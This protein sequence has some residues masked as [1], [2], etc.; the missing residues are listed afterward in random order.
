M[1]GREGSGAEAVRYRVGRPGRE[2]ARVP[3]LCATSKSGLP[4]RTL[5]MAM[6]PRDLD[7][8]VSKRPAELVPKEVSPGSFPA[9]DETVTT[10][11]MPA[12]YRW[13]AGVSSVIAGAA[14]I[15]GVVG[16]VNG[17][18]LDNIGWIVG[19]LTFMILAVQIMR[20]GVAV[21]D[22]AVVVRNLIGTKR[23]ALTSVTGVEPAN[24]A[25]ATAQHGPKRRV[26]LVVGSRRVQV[27]AL[28]AP[29]ADLRV[30]NATRLW[31]L[32]YP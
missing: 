2:W 22:E 20:C 8:A 15:S 11:G 26:Y 19:G 23:I 27:D 30:A 1:V 10:L 28:Q 4:S 14:T 9:Q 32:L 29:E 18:G 7:R 21:E 24:L 25:E 5:G 16:M 3:A 6:D 13:S 31:Q 17:S 12:V